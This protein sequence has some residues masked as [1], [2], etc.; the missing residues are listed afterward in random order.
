MAKSSSLDSGGCFSSLLRH[1]L[2]RNGMPAHP[3]TDPDQSSIVEKDEGGGAVGLSSSPDRPGLV[4]RLMG[5]ETLPENPGLTAA[6]A[7]LGRRSP[8]TV[9]RSLSV[10]SMDYL[11]EID[12]LQVPVSRHRRVHTS[13][14]FREEAP[15]HL[16]PDLL[17]MYLDELEMKPKKEPTQRAKLGRQVEHPKVNNTK[18]KVQKVRNNEARR[19]S[20]KEEGQQQHGR[21]NGKGNHRGKLIQEKE[22]MAESKFTKKRKEGKAIKRVSVVSVESDGSEASS[23]I[24]VLNL[25]NWPNVNELGTGSPMQEVPEYVNLSPKKE[26]LKSPPSRFL[27]PAARISDSFELRRGT[28][29]RKEVCDIDPVSST[30][31]VRLETNDYWLSVAREVYKLTEEDVV[32]SSHDWINIDSSK[33]E[34][35]EKL[36]KEI[37]A[38]IEHRILEQVV[39][40]LICQT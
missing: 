20:Y 32:K 27:L 36:L 14:S 5:L 19:V 25:D 37:S 1:L 34:G 26:L 13:V 17:V 23:P 8:N 29:G 18:M 38:L 7:K 30:A 35:L 39:R 12:F 3:S 22:M 2:C 10:N 9:P 33:D 40:E 16:Q 24:S 31:G 4:A 15:S 28:S 11:L 21:K 6:K